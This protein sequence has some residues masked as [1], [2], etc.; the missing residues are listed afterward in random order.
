MN[1]G[2]AL[3]PTPR[4]PK[5]WGERLQKLHIDLWLLMLLLAVAVIGLITQYSASGHSLPALIAQGQRLLLIN[6]LQ[7]A[8]AEHHDLRRIPRLP[9]AGGLGGHCLAR[10]DALRRLQRGRRAARQMAAS[11]G[12]GAVA[13]QDQ[14]LGRQHRAQAGHCRAGAQVGGL[15]HLGAR[16]QLRGVATQAQSCAA[17]VLGAA[18]T[19]KQA[20][21]ANEASGQ[22]AQFVQVVGQRIGHHQ[23]QVTGQRHEA[24]VGVV[25]GADFLDREMALRS[26]GDVAR[27]GDV[28]DCQARHG[29]AITVHIGQAEVAAEH[30]G[31]QFVHRHHQG[32]DA[33]GAQ[34][35]RAGV[36]Q[37]HIGRA[38]VG[39]VD[40]TGGGQ[41]D[42]AQHTG[43]DSGTGVERRVGQQADAARRSHH[44]LP[45]GAQTALLQRPKRRGA[46]GFHH[47]LDAQIGHGTDL[48]ITQGV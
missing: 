45:V 43:G 4:S 3:T 37:R 15:D 9:Q 20:R 6:A 25:A 29:F 7:R 17:A 32:S 42:L 13:A 28:L 21:A 18:G 36:D 41:A 16:R 14:L 26:D 46:T 30:I 11:Q 34:A 23:Q 10:E 48:Q 8:V 40:R 39:Q 2:T 12:D 44:N 27:R 22:Q 5:T 19:G 35:E 33:A 38:Q 24:H 47:P 1:T 31:A